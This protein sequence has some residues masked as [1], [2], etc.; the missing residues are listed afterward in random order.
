[1]EVSGKLHVPA[2][3]TPENSHGT[4]WKEVGW[5]LEPVWTILEESKSLA[6]AGFR[7][8]ELSA[9]SLVIITTELSWLQNEVEEMIVGKTQKLKQRGYYCVTCIDIHKVYILP[10]RCIYVV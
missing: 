3:L 10:A 4:H 6:I 7:T 1:M 2:A 5:E 8:P 9:P